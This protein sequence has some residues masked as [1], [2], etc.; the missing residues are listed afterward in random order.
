MK[1]ATDRKLSMKKRNWQQTKY[2]KEKQPTA[3]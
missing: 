2:M 1:Q 3:N